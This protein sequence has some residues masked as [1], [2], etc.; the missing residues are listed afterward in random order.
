MP[1][2]TGHRWATRATGIIKLE[3][4]LGGGSVPDMPIFWH[5]SVSR[6]QDVARACSYS[7]DQKARVPWAIGRGSS[8]PSAEATKMVCCPAAS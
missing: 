3:S 7:H 8:F 5:V 2:G 1:A 4:K 6:E